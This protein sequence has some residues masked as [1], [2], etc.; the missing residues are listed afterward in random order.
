MLR[1]LG[2]A[3]LLVALAGEGRAAVVGTL[4]FVGDSITAPVA[5]V[6]TF[7]STLTV[8]DGLKF[9]IAP[10]QHGPVQLDVLLGTSNISLAA[11]AI[12][13]VF[14]VSPTL[15][16]TITSPDLA[17]GVH[18]FALSALAA[19]NAAIGY[20]LTLTPLPGAGILLAGSL[21]A[22]GWLGRRGRP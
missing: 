14:K 17:Q 15:P 21:L 18:K 12:E 4:D 6:D 16:F 1:V 11:A 22:L 7:N 5:F 9:K 13:T 10:G 8:A 20:R 2:A 3:A 19:G